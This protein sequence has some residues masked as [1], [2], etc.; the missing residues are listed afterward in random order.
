MDVLLDHWH[1][2]NRRITSTSVKV[3]A[4]HLQ[5]VTV[6]KV[7]YLC[8]TV[9]IT[10]QDQNWSIHVHPIILLAIFLP[11]IVY[12]RVEGY[13]YG[14]SPLICNMICNRNSKIFAFLMYWFLLIKVQ[15]PFRSWNIP[16][17]LWNV[18]DYCLQGNFRTHKDMPDIVLSL[19]WFKV[20][21]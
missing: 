20:Y 3:S 10:I 19:F 15:H 7:L 2:A 21:P 17:V 8:T 13:K 6:G 5:I 14:S 4:R 11:R 1:T 12:M 16:S 18:S 9:Y